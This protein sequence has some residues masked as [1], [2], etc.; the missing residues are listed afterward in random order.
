[1][2]SRVQLLAGTTEG[3]FIYRA[4]ATRQAWQCNGPLFP[5][6]SIDSV[7]GDNLHGARIFAGMSH[8]EQGPRLQLS[9][10]DGTT[11]QA[12]ATAPHYPPE[13][14]LTVRRIWQ[15]IPSAPSEPDTY[16]AGVDE[17]GLFVSHDRGLQWQEILGLNRHADRVHWRASRG[18]LTLHAILIDPTDPRRLWVAIAS[19]GIWRTVDGGA[20]WQACNQGL[21]TFN[22]ADGPSYLVHKLIQDPTDPQQLYLQNIDGVYQSS[23]GADSWQPIEAGL[24]STFGFPFGVDQLGNRYVVPLEP[25]S[26]GAFDGR[27][28]IYRRRATEQRW[29][30]QGSGLPTTAARVG[31]LRNALTVDSLA[32]PALYVGTTEGTL[33]YSTDSGEQWTQLPSPLA[34]VTALQASVHTEN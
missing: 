30:T 25:E 32:Q 22:S 18:G 28:R 9:T 15:I 17:A 34:R 27:L 29:S 7:W 10:D 3:L 23:D 4:D 21:R 20:T 31:V 8:P 14:G 16:Y 12:L 2:P 11:W 6:W 26:R 5:G 24:P 13:S 19:A 33:F 1:M